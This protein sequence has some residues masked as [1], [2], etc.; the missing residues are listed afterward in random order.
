MNEQ[1]LE[2][3]FTKIQQ[4][5][6]KRVDKG[7]VAPIAYNEEAGLAFAYH[8]VEEAMELV[9]EFSNRKCWKEH[10][11][12]NKQRAIEEGVDIFI[13]LVITLSY[14]DINSKD[15][16]EEVLTKLGVKREDWIA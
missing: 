16:Y 6:Q 7:L 12:V 8:T 2:L 1:T 15:L 4:A 14:L 11:P 13:M 3:L 10:T 5:H 9:Q